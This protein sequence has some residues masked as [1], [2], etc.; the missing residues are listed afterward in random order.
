MKLASISLL[1]VL[2]GCATASHA[3][4]ETLLAAPINCA[5]AQTDIAALEAA[6]PSRGER[7]R[8]AVQSVTPVGAIGGVV[9]GTYDERLGVLTGATEEEL[10]ARIEAIQS[11]CT[12]ADAPDTG[13]KKENAK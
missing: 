12:L 8:S 5:T 7:A 9:S 1:A 2:A 13:Q 4:R 6:M 11:E 3:D 10:S